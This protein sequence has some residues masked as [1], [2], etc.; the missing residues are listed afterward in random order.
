MLEF[1]GYYIIG[2]IFMLLIGSVF[3]HKVLYKDNK[4]DYE[5]QDD[6]FALIILSFISWIGVF[7]FIMSLVLSY[8][9]NNT[10]KKGKDLW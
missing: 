3:Y 5:L 6:R 10:F 1:L 4:Y 7:V 8:I 9:I 2:V